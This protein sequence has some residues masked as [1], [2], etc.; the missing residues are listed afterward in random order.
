MRFL[1][2]LIK[3]G[4]HYTSKVQLMGQGKEQ[5]QR[6]QPAFKEVSPKANPLPLISLPGWEPTPC[7][8]KPFRKTVGDRKIF[9]LRDH[10]H[11]YTST[12]ATARGIYLLALNS[13]Y[14]FLT[15]SH[16]SGN[17]RKWSFYKLWIRHQILAFTTSFQF[18]LLLIH[19]MGEAS[20]FA[21]MEIIH[22]IKCLE[23]KK[24]LFTWHFCIFLKTSLQSHALCVHVYT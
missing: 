3:G 19:L 17:N 13:P 20:N 15:N 12:H 22:F 8:L 6:Q 21:H 9:L 14:F 7:S 16:N 23:W 24:S 11:T 18:L 2:H 4:S 10:T 1:I 5:V